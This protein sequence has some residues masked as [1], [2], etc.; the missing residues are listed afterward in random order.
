MRTT[1]YSGPAF[2]VG[3]EDFFQELHALLQ[4]K[5]RVALSAPAG[6]GKTAVAAE[7]A[8]RFSHAYERIF[9]MNMASAE[10]WLADS[11]ELAERLALPVEEDE[12][13]LVGINQVIQNWL[14]QHPDSLLIVDNV[15]S[16]AL[17]AT[18]KQAANHTLFLTRQPIND[19]SLAHLSLTALGAE[20][21]AL[22]LLRQSGQLAVEAPLAQAEAEVRA[23]ALRL[24]D[25]LS[26]LPLAL[27]LAAAN[28][29]MSGR[30]VQEFLELY[31]QY[32]ERLVQLKTSKGKSADALAITCSLPAIRLQRTHQLASELLSFCVILAPLALPRELFLQGAGEL[33]PALQE[34]AHNPA[35]LDEALDR[36][37]SLGLLLA[38]EKGK[39][40]S[41]QFTV[42]ETLFQALPQEKR[43]ELIVHAL[44]AISHLLPTIDQAA[45]AIRMQMAA[46]I[47]HLILASS[48][49]IIPHGA[50][51]DAFGWASSLLWEYG[52][53]QDAELLLRKAL[54]IWER[55][56]GTGHETVGMAT[57]NLGVLCALLENYAE[58][59]T[60]LQSA[61]LARSRALGAAHPEVI[62]CLL[63]LASIYA[64][65]NK[66]KEAR[67]CYQEALKIG[68]PTLGQE[69]PLL[70]TAA[71]KL[72]MF[73]A[74]DDEF[75]EAETYYRR[76]L[77]IYQA[78]QGMEDDQ[79][80]VC[81]E[82]LA[83]VLLEQE[84]YA[85][86]EE[87]LRSLLKVYEETLGLENERTQKCLELVSLVAFQQ[88]K[89]AEA[90]ALLQRLLTVKERTLGET[91]PETRQLMQK[92][93]EFAI[94]Q[95]ELARAEQ[96]YQ[97]L[98]AFYET[99]SG[100]MEAEA[101]PY[102]EHLALIYLQQGKS[103]EAERLLRRLS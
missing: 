48:D 5:R 14:A 42:Q 101:R 54:M 41:V 84:K 53:L 92:V 69:H 27:H 60:L 21:G 8:R 26:G 25:E 79:T 77:P 68:E 70:V 39:A 17:P 16:I 38:D 30:S 73:Y 86:A 87:L 66:R 55:V 36:L 93:A 50:V 76:V 57:R 58:A 33:T 62:L 67:A 97:R 81:F 18:V 19:P 44:R 64:R 83:D 31:H 65:Q 3:R 56:L 75:A 32:V 61:M 82:Q 10:C 13:D 1:V 94:V 11:L 91:H 22:L 37:S 72:A 43:N 95:G 99:A 12:W 59:E 40:L 89:Y 80:Q 63:D 100:Q 102:L 98:C 35:L 71:H 2:F 85:E 90:E 4:S 47:L 7:Y 15:G 96:I 23:Q 52:L 49:W 20:E 78:S 24:A 34:L 46:Q 9:H 88:E 74:E 29:R 6:M 28:M 45:P 51:A 103:E